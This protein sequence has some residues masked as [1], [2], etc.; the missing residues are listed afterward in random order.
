MYPGKPNPIKLDEFKLTDQ[1][2]EELANEL[3]AQCQKGI[4]PRE[5][6]YQINRLIAGLGDKRGLLRRTFS[7]SLGL[8]G[9]E[10][11]PALREVLLHHPNVTV[12]RAAAKTLRLVG[13]EKALPDL[14]KALLNDPDPVVQGSS[15]GAMAIFGAK[16]VEELLKVLINSNHTEMQYGLATWGLE[17]IGSQAP[18]SLKNAA[19]SKNPRIRAAAIGALGEQIHYLSDHSAKEL[20][21]KALEDTDQNVRTSATRLLGEFEE[22]N[23][24]EKLLIPK[25]SDT[26][27]DVR[28]HAAISLMRIDSK[29]ALSELEKNLADEKVI[30]VL[31]VFKLAIKRIRESI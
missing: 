29:K 7:E 20:V 2:A 8:I 9:K 26:S 21:I 25:L 28:K 3:K 18:E 11:L 23:L 1:E 19:K 24:I 22:K 10:T 15:V 17:F 16:A 12:R 13:D 30:E 14:L 5:D 31:K 27:Q 6:S 4:R